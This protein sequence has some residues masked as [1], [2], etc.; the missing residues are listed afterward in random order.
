MTEYIVLLA[1]LLSQ[2]TGFAQSVVVVK[3]VNAL[4]GW[5]G[6]LN[7]K[8]SLLTL[9]HLSHYFAN[10]V[11]Y[12]VNDVLVAKNS[13]QLLDRFQSM[14]RHIK[15]YHT[16]LPENT[17]VIHGHQASITYQVISVTKNARHHHDLIAARI[18][19]NQQG[20]ITGWDALIQYG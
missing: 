19:Y 9:N 18:H 1:L 20:K 8:H 14:L 16:V 5:M 10:N 6:T 12:K 11:R 7:H 3:R 13:K 2:V 4:F 17:T 15:S